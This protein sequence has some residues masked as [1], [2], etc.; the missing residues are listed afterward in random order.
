MLKLLFSGV[1]MLAMTTALSAQEAPAAQPAPIE[2]ETLTVEKTIKPG[3][4][5]LVLDQSWSGSSRV[6]VY[7]AADLSMQGNIGTGLVAEMAVSPDGKSLY[8]ASA[9]AKRITRGETEAIVTEFDIATLSDKREIPISNRF[10]QVSSQPSLLT[11]VDGGKYLLAQNATPATSVSVV[12]LAAGKQIAEIPT[13]GCWGI[14]ATESGRGFMTLCG[15]GSM[16]VYTFA[17]DGTFGD[18]KTGKAIFD[19]DKDALYT[20]PARTKDGFL[21][22]SFNGNIHDVRIEDGTPKLVDKFS[23]TEGTEGWAP[24]GTSSVIAYSQPSG[25]AFVLMHSDAKDGSHKNPAEEIWAVDVAG[26]KTLYRSKADE[27]TAIIVSQDM[28]PV[29][30][31]SG[32]EKS[33]LNRYSVDP[34][35]KFAARPEQ[36]AEELGSFPT[37]LLLAK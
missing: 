14:L 2:P 16:K 27:E 37:M 31:A 1:A 7:S 32:D 29:L 3:P 22:M 9:Y 26:K 8:T 12:D 25:V 28:P 30:Y 35:A 20:N 36:K 6:N 33:E 23:I 19:P 10:A 21:F 13:P 11:F 5:V 15:D 24:G 17:E 34:E 4:N 18:P